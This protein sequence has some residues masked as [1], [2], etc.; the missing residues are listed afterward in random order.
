MNI[1]LTATLTLFLTSFS[2]AYSVQPMVSELKP[3]GAEASRVFYIENT[4]NE[5][6]AVQISAFTRAISNSGE[7]VRKETQD[8]AIYP[9]QVVINAKEKKSVRVTYVG[10]KELK[11]QIPYRISFDQLP[12]DLKKKK[13]VSAAEVKFMFNYVT[14]VY[15]TPDG[16]EPKIE[17]D[18]QELKN[19]KLVVQ[20][21]NKG[22]AYRLLSYY[23]LVLKGSGQEYKISAEDQKVVDGINLLPGVRRKIEFH[24]PAEAAKEKNLGIQLKSKKL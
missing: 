6:L 1:I 22:T 7:E 18:S 2:W 9:D 4:N 17:I 16:A 13:Q 24:V 15:V 10:P 14:A 20:F 21:S 5:K 23:D 3:T 8:F 19:D 11:Q 12:V